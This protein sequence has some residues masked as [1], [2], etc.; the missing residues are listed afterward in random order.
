MIA[1]HL[2]EQIEHLLAE[3]RLS[4]RKIA[5]F[6]GVSRGTIGAIASGRRQVRPRKI[7]PWEEE[8]EVPD[9]PPERCPTCGGMVYMPC[10]LCRTKKAV[11]TMP[12]LRATMLA[13]M[14]QRV[15]PLG[16]NLKSA[17]HQRYEEVRRWRREGILLG[18]RD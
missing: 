9:S 6:T 12:A 13:R 17:H 3:G 1:A 15:E 10:R 16:L 4:H 14:R 5:R 8:A 2:V 18:M 11:A 7:Y